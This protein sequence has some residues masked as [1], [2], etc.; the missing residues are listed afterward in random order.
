MY[1][2]AGTQQRLRRDT[3]PVGALS[4]DQLALDYG[5]VH[6]A[7]SQCGRAVLAGGAAAEND[8]VVVI[9][10]AHRHL[11]RFFGLAPKQV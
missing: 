10:R 1:R 5:D 4:A 2:L 8:H 11:R 7:S 9:G 6:S 3:C